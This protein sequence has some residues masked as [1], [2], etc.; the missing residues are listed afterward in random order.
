ML[1]TTSKSTVTFPLGTH[2]C[3]KKIIL[4]FVHSPGKRKRVVD[5]TAVAEI[6]NKLAAC[7][8]NVSDISLE[9]RSLIYST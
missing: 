5:D 1:G 8:I 7:D 6:T 4:Y 3:K 9:V 2:S